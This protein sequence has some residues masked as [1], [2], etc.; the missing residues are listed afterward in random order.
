MNVSSALE[1]A[2]EALKV[3][4][5]LVCGRY[6][7]GGVKAAT[8]DL[9]Q[10]LA[11][12]WLE[13]IRRL[14]HSYAVDLAQQ[15]DIEARRVRLTERDR[16]SSARL[17]NA[18][19]VKAWRRRANRPVHGLIYGLEDGRLLDLYCSIGSGHYQKEITE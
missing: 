10:S 7:C 18:H 15:P 1:F 11:D 14:A 13:P 4:E 6:G 2:V 3:R 17:R 16:G 8:E 12:H 9:S 5:N 19:P